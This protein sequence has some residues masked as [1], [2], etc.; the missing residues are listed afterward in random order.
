MPAPDTIVDVPLTP[1]QQK[2]QDDLL[3][4]L[5]QPPDAGPLARRMNDIARSVA[6]PKDGSR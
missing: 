4:R 6:N 1:E 2:I 3:K 5:S